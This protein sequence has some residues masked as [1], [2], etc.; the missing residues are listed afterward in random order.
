MKIG[1]STGCLYPTDTLKGIEN[2][3]DA[4]F[5]R[6]EIFFNTFS[7]LEADYLERIR[8]LLIRRNGSVASVHPFTSSYES[9]LLFSA[10]EKRFLDGISFYEMYFR[11]AKRLGADKVVLHGMQDR[12]SAAVDAAEY[13]RRFAMLARRAREYGVTLLQE[14]VNL[15]VANAPDFIMKM[16]ELIPDEAYFVLDTKQALLGGHRPEELAGI[17]GDRMLHL[18]ISD[19]SKDGSC[20][21]PGCGSEDIPGFINE[22]SRLGYN[23][24]LMIEVYRFSY[25]EASELSE[26]K[27]Y[28]DRLVADTVGN[29]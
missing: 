15:C 1:V 7:E 21:L 10:H 11:T 3:L 18:H 24:D 13:C 29:K 14:N 5:D 8:N 17:M 27:K 20:V 22:L 16:I 28:L 25:T 2:L 26:A 4:G 23:G 9:F 12:F 6:F 19:R